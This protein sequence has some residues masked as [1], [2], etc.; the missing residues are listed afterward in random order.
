MNFEKYEQPQMVKINKSRGANSRGDLMAI[1]SSRVGT[2]LRRGFLKRANSRIYGNPKF[3]KYPA[4]SY[5]RISFD[6]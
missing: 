3:F 1:L 5:K 4:S 6:L 2:Y